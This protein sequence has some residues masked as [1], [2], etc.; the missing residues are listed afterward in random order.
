MWNRDIRAIVEN[1][2][3]RVLSIDTY[4]FGTTF[5]IVAEPYETSKPLDAATSKKVL[6]D[7]LIYASSKKNSQFSR[8]EDVA[9]TITDFA[10]LSA[11]KIMPIVVSPCLPWVNCSCGRCECR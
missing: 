9:G 3:L 2:G 10:V 4:H 1:S 5:Y 11:M 6:R 8:L 7:D